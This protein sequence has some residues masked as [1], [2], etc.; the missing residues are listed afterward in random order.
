[1]CSYGLCGVLQLI[2]KENVCT[3]LWHDPHLASVGEEGAAGSSVGGSKCSADL[4]CDCISS[5]P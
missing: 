3:Q 2:V 4:V 1:M 5:S